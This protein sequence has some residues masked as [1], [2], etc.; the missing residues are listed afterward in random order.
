MV[1]AA[2]RRG[3]TS[4]RSDAVE[5]RARAAD[6]RALARGGG[7]EARRGALH[8]GGP[9][10]PGARRGS[11]G[12]SP[13]WGSHPPA[14]SARRVPRRRVDERGP[15]FDRPGSGENRRRAG[16]GPGSAAGPARGGRR[17]G[18]EAPFHAVSRRLTRPARL[19]SFPG[20]PIGRRRTVSDPRHWSALRTRSDTKHVPSIPGPL[21]RVGG[22]FT[23]PAAPV[24][25][26]SAACVYVETSPTLR[27]RGGNE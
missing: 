25:E 18:G 1:G 9:G 10:A 4:G 3:R 11:G 23:S 8:A 2:R 12:G 5:A 13:A 16:P 7:R 19:L 20:C 22:F 21:A 17:P 6:R 26:N 15:P 27:G 24:F 14:R